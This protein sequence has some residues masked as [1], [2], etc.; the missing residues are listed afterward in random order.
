MIVMEYFSSEEGQE[1]GVDANMTP[2]NGDLQDS[3]A[4][5]QQD[6]DMEEGRSY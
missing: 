6:Q 3:G 4:S 1:G 5:N 2:L